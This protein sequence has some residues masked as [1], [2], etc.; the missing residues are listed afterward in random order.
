MNSIATRTFKTNQS[1]FSFLGMLFWIAL[2]GSL[3]IVAM[4]VTPVVSE[5][6]AIKSAITKAKTESTAPAIRQAFDRIGSATYINEFKGADL[7]IETKNGLLTVGF[8]YERRVPLAGP[9]SLLFNFSG[10]DA[11]R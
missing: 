9:V 6:F 8:A 2:L 5:Y 1:G 4:K 11:V 10:E 7:N 3:I